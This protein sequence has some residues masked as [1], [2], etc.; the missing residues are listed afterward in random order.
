MVVRIEELASLI[1]EDLLDKP[2][3]VFY[4][5]RQA[6]ESPSDLYILGLNS[7]GD[8]GK[9]QETIG[10]HRERVLRHSGAG[11]SRYVEGL[12]PFH[13]RMEYLFGALGCCPGHVPAS[14]IV[15]LR[16]KRAKEIP[17]TYWNELID[18]CWRFHKAVIEILKVRVIVCLGKD[19]GEAVRRM[20]KCGKCVVDTFTENYEIRKTRSFTC[21][22]DSGLSVVQLTHPSYA[23][24]MAPAADPTGL[25]TRAMEWASVN[26]N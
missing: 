21:R 1:P 17:Q 6:F 26:P 19:S 2:G 18:K 24:W 22:N 15:F 7:G 4:S 23:N 9:E 11:W 5:G 10:E 13:R 8:P 14:N 20:L 16:S 25:V 3:R 12:R